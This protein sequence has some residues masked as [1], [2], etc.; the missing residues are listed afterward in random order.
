MLGIHGLSML[1]NLSQSEG[2]SSFGCCHCSGFLC[3]VSP[4]APG[5]T[6]VYCDQVTGYPVL[7]STV[8]YTRVPG[9]VL[10]CTRYCTVQY[11]TVRVLYSTVLYYCTVYHPV[12]YCMVYSYSTVQYYID[13]RLWV[14]LIV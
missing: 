5:Y 4:A 13:M 12:L 2:V 10:Y 8:Q 6:F 3:F 1:A 11:C 9:T 7:Y 14:F